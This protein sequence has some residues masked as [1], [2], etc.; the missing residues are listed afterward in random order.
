MC[1]DSPSSSQGGPSEPAAGTT[2]SSLTGLCSPPKLATLHLYKR[3]TNIDRQ[4]DVLMSS[5]DNGI[6]SQNEIVRVAHHLRE[7]SE[8]L[9]IPSSQSQEVAL[10][11]SFHDGNELP[12]PPKLWS[13]D[14]YVP[15]SQS[16]EESA[17]RLPEIAHLSS[18]CGG[19]NREDII[20]SSQSQEHELMMPGGS[21]RGMFKSSSS[22]LIPTS[23]Y[24]EVELRMPGPS[25]QS[26]DLWVINMDRPTANTNDAPAQSRMLVESPQPISSSCDGSKNLTGSGH[27]AKVSASE[28]TRSPQP[29]TGGESQ[30]H[31]NANEGIANINSA[32]AKCHVDDRSS[33]EPSSPLTP[34][35]SSSSSPSSPQR[36]SSVRSSLA[37]PSLSISAASET[38]RNPDDREFMEPPPSQAVEAFQGISYHG[39][40]QRS[41]TPSQVRMFRDMFDE[42]PLW[43]MDEDHRRLGFQ[44]DPESF[45]Q[46]LPTGTQS[47]ADV[48]SPHGTEDLRI[49]VAQARNDASGEDDWFEMEGAGAGGISFNSAGSSVPQVVDDFLALFSQPGANGD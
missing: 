46:R 49:R 25:Q 17:F 21:T 16:Q 31:P 36:T 24:D 38:L 14:V 47:Q 19:H 48:Y 23:Q 27:R 1:S 20:P 18:G 37:P 26:G 42:E 45:A 30:A 34:L 32:T 9:F 12:D 8:E 10:A 28:N 40:S 11:P 4:S 22:S 13:E 44:V 35:T 3:P 15:S 2:P 5:D 7:P 39:M 6:Q 29:D 41:C 43:L 33:V